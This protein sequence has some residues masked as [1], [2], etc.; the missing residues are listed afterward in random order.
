VIKDEHPWT[1]HHGDNIMDKSRD[2][3]T[4]GPRRMPRLERPLITILERSLVA[5]ASRAQAQVAEQYEKIQA[6]SLGR[7]K[8]LM[9]DLVPAG[10]DRLRLRR[11]EKQL[12]VRPGD[13]AELPV[14]D[15]KTMTRQANHRALKARKIRI[16]AAIVRDRPARRRA[17]VM[18]DFFHCIPF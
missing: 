5:D 13:P 11:V 1:K 15:R 6:L 16:A 17:V 2:E 7:R 12:V 9:L 18:H 3:V 8:D 14:E 10:A 4:V